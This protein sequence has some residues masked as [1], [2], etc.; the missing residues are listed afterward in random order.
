[1][2][3]RLDNDLLISR[4]HLVAALRLAADNP[5]DAQ[6]LQRLC[7]MAADEIERLRDA[8]VLP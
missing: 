1:M 2:M 7:R 3:R 5:T 8:L 6:L 4:A